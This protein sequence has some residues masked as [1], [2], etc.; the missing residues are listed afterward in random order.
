MS[1]RKEVKNRCMYKG[2]DN[3]DVQISV[4]VEFSGRSSGGRVEIGGE[5]RGVWEERER[6]SGG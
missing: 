6:K 3:N 2:D 1:E 5:V 4:R